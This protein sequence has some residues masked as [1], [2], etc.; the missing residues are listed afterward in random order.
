[1][2]MMIQMLLNNAAKYSAARKSEE[3]NS[4]IF[5]PAVHI[6]T[7]MNQ[8]NLVLSIKDNGI[9]LRADEIKAIFKPFWRSEEVKRLSLPGTGVGLT[10]AKRFADR[11]KIG[12]NIRSPGPMAGTTAS[13]I[14]HSH[15][16]E[17]RVTV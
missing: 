8:G 11:L 3:R 13:L 15:Q 12:L 5:L 6:E 9:G 10:L 7:H 1:V 2:R 16:F 4:Q 17:R 14:F